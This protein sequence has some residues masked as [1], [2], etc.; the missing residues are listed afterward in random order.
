MQA[1]RRADLQAPLD[2]DHAIIPPRLHHLPVDARGAHEA[3]DHPDVVFEAIRGDQRG[4]N[5]AA[6]EDDVVEGSCGVSRR[7]AAEPAPGPQ[8]R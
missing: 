2:S 7:A 1:A 5:Q 8:A 6:S 3:P 4:A